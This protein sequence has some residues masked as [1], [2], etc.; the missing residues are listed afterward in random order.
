LVVTPKPDAVIRV[1]MDF[2]PLWT[3]ESAHALAFPPVPQRRGFTIV[4]WGGI[5]R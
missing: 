2:R 5:L 1:L 3:R 4:E